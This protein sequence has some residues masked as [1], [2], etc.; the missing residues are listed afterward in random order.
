MKQVYQGFFINKHTYSDTSLLLSFYSQSQGLQK[1]VFK[2]G[3][4]KTALLPFGRY[5]IEATKKNGFDFAFV[6]N[7]SN[8]T[9]YF[10]TQNHPLKNLIAFFICD[11]I[12][13]STPASHTDSVTFETLCIVAD[14]LNEAT[15]LYDFPLRFLNKWILSLGICPQP[16]DSPTAFDIE[17]GLFLSDTRTISP[18]NLD[19]LTWNQ[20][21][22]NEEIMDKTGVKPAINLIM[23]YIRFHIPNFKFEKTLYILQQTLLS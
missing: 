8:H 2:G 16:V 12:Y 6:N 17:N 9:H 4:K 22:K 10:S 19:V 20:S 14:D 18:A 5:E 13:Q 3:R 1:F 7:I 21:L 23:K 15:E 11:V